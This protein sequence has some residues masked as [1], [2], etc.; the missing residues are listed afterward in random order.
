MNRNAGKTKSKT[1]KEIS[2][3]KTQ[4][5]V[6]PINYSRNMKCEKLILKE[7]FNTLAMS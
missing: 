3:K 1:S 6:Y 7:A 5:F 4:L 2:Q